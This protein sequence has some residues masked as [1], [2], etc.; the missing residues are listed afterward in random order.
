MPA[1]VGDCSTP[2]RGIFFESGKS[3][4]TVRQPERRVLAGALVGELLLPFGR[5][6]RHFAISM[7]QAGGHIPIRV[8]CALTYQAKSGSSQRQSAAQLSDLDVTLIDPKSYPAPGA[9][10]TWRQTHDRVA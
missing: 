8:G 9:C 4:L 2:P 3:A 7:H 6:V 1:P 10:W 5:V